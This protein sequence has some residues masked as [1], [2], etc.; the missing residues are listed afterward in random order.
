M[1]LL[2]VAGSARLSDNEQTTTNTNAKN[3]IYGTYSDVSGGTELAAPPQAERFEENEYAG[4]ARKLADQ[5]RVLQ[6]RHGAWCAEIG[7][8]NFE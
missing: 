4:R 7:G 8:K 6:M 3:P 5:R 2:D 1:D